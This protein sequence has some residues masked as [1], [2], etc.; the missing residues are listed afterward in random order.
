MNISA[1]FVGN[2]NFMLLLELLVLI[3]AVGLWLFRKSTFD[4]DKRSLLN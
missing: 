2:C 4:E 3:V 1:Y